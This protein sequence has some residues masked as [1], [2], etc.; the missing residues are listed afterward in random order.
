MKKLSP[1]KMYSSSKSTA[2]VFI[3][4]PSEVDSNLT[5]NVPSKKID[6]KCE[7]LKLNFGTINYFK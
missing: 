6:Y 5:T 4:S 7:H 2:L 3:D 1:K